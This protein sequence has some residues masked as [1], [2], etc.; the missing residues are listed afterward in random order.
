MKGVSHGNADKVQARNGWFVG[1][2]VD[3]DPYRQTRDVEIK[4]KE[5]QP[6][7]KKGPFESNH[8][9]RS[10]SILI[11]GSFVFEFE[12]QNER[13]KVLRQEVRLKKPGD[14]AIWLLG[15]KH[16]GYTQVKNTRMLTIRW[17]SVPEDH[18]EVRNQVGT[19]GKSRGKK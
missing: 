11:R 10:M 13:Q 3:N 19:S 2:F 5:H 7:S 4:W 15:V 8:S 18:F 9:A 17:P 14:Y 12:R 1:F 16:R 6:R